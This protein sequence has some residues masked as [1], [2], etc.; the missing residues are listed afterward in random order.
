[1]ASP[2]HSPELAAPTS[3]VADSTEAVDYIQFHHNYKPNHTYQAETYYS[4]HPFHIK[5]RLTFLLL[6]T[7]FI[8]KTSNI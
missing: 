1:M 2:L 3:W 6:S 8:E 7:N 5:S 4:I